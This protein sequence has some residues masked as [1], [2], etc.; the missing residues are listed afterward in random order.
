MIALDTNV[1]VR[2]FV[3]DDPR[4]TQSVAALVNTLSEEQPGWISMVALAELAWVLRS[5]YHFPHEQL[6]RA[7]QTLIS[8]KDLVVESEALVRQSL[9]QYRNGKSDFADCLISASA[10]AAGCART[11]TFDQI[12]ARDAGMELIG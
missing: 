2:Y 8:S 12:A 7:I 11:V 9:A 6:A 1:L 4:Q 5:M 3:K 10:R